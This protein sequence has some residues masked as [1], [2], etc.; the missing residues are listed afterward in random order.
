MACYRQG[1]PKTARQLLTEAAKLLDQNVSDPARFPLYPGSSRYQN[2]WLTALLLHREA[3]STDAQ[4]YTERGR[5]NFG[6]GQAEKAAA[7]FRKAVELLNDKALEK[8]LAE[9]VASE[10]DKL[11]ARLADDALLPKLTAAIERNPDD[12]ARRWSRAEWYA[13][14]RRW[15]EAAADFRNWLERQPLENRS[16]DDAWH[17]LH[18]APTLVAA[19]DREGYRR[20]CREMLERFGDT[21]DPTTANRIALACLLLPASGKDMDLACQLADRA[22]MLGKNSS[23]QIGFISCKGLADYRRGND[24]AAAEALD[25]LASRTGENVS[26]ICHLILTMACHRQ[27]DAK[28]A[29]EH[30]TRAAKLLDQYVSDPAR[31]PQHQGRAYQHEWLIVWLL[32]REAQTNDVEVYMERGRNYFALGQID[33]ATAEFRKAVDL[34]NDRALEPLASPPEPATSEADKLLARLADDALLPKLTAAIERN[35]DDM[36]RR[37]SRAEW[38]ARHR[39]WKE[40]AADFQNWL[41][42][43][44]LENRSMHDAWSWHHTA[45]TLVAAGDREGYRRLCREMLQRFGDTQDPITAERIALAC[46]LLPASGKDMDLA[47]QLAD[48]SVTLRKKGSDDSLSVLCKGLADYRRENYRAAAEALDPLASRT[49][50]TVSAICRLILT[51]AC[52]RQGDA[53]AARDHQTKAA[54]LLDP[55]VSDPARFPHDPGF[56]YRHDGLIAWL[57]YRE[58]QTTDAQAYRERGRTYF[59]LGQT[60]KATAEFRK[61]VELLND[62]ALEPLASPPEPATSEADKLL[63]R[64]ADDALLPKLTAAIERTPDDMARRWSRGE[65]YAR[66]ARWKEAAADFQLWLE[67][68]PLENRSVDDAWHW[69][70]AAPTLVAAGDREG[71]RRLCREMLKRFGDTQELYTA[72][73]I[74]RACLLL[75]ASGKDMEL[76]C[77]LADRTVT[78]GKKSS[79]EPWF[80]YCKGL[81]DYRRGNYR[82]AEALDPLASGGSGALQVGCRLILA[83]ACYRQGEPK[84]ARQH[85]TEAAK[86]L[87][88]N[89][90]DPARFPRFPGISRYQHDWLRAWLLQREAQTLI[91]GAKDESKK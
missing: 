12:M 10:A 2:D 87:D 22:V 64:L 47:C 35:P 88:Q 68:Q 63:A 71:Y 46:L 66:R 39:R 75:P 82:A 19:G 14:H 16:V 72:E 13:R 56:R 43:Q 89:V 90:S 78:L 54:K 33:K 79:D 30:L 86:L 27:G 67:R 49:G 57:L 40:A 7:D 29:R 15:K 6:L 48:R 4:P 42:R 85:L 55:Y 26:A 31:F 60:D 9:P 32:H 38:Y 24:R 1:E 11:L 23:D 53:K 62:R 50:D 41:E 8:L 44:P 74:A 52:Y 76:A 20:L 81:A 25:P 3:Q 18:V 59:A 70:F 37:W 21:Q 80:I 36:A 28:A 83:M 17:W 77:Q 84:T 65:W 73:R 69:A 5:T 34:L 61:A 91:E 45:P 51:M 58:A